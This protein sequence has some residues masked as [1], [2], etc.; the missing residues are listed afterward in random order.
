VTLLR[1]KP[2]GSPRLAGRIDEI[3]PEG[4][5]A[6]VRVTATPTIVAEVTAASA[7]TF[8]V[9]ESVWVSVKATEVTLY[10]A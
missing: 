8:G 6:R 3:D 10:P 4:V 1:A 2:D 5:V 9:G 7:D